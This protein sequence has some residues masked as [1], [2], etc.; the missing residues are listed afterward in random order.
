MGR[1]CAYLRQFQSTLPRGSDIKFF[2]ECARQSIISIHVPLRERPKGGYNVAKYFVHFNPHS[3]AGAT[4]ASTTSGGGCLIFQS[5]L[6]YGSDV[7]HAEEPI[8]TLR[9]S[10]HAPSRERQRRLAAI[11]RIRHFNPRSL[12]GATNARNNAA[13]SREFQSTLPCGSDFDYIAL[14]M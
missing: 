5:T 3:L 7:N 14:G 1:W 4:Q 13:L 10:I 6:P 12:T 11:R 9:I 2:S 8:E